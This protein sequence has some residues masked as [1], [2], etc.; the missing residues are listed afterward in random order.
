MIVVIVVIVIVVISV[1]IVIVV[2]IVINCYLSFFD[3]QTLASVIISS[4]VF[5]DDDNEDINIDVLLDDPIE[6]IFT[7]NVSIST[8]FPVAEDRSILPVPF[9]III[10]HE[11]LSCLTTSYI[12]L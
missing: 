10:D 2:I 9:C 4:Q 8:Q 11:L 3:S 7:I 12:A 1:I 5:T 6:I